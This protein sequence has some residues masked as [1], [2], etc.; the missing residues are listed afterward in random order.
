MTI[1][2]LLF[3]LS[4]TAFAQ[5]KSASDEP[6]KIVKFYPN[7]ATSIV[8]ITKASIPLTNTHVQ[9]IS[10]N[11]SVVLQARTGTINVGH[12]AAGVYTVRITTND[13]KTETGKLVIKR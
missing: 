8:T 6:A 2:L 10:S 5:L 9:I 1:L 3:G 12:L 7:P 4:F 13:G 11:G